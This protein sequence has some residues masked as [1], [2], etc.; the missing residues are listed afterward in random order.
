MAA[1]VYTPPNAGLSEDVIRFVPT[2]QEVTVQPCV[3]KL[4]ISYSSRSLEAEI[5][6]FVNPASSNILRAFLDR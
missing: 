4:L 2:P 1:S 5:I 6:A 3:F